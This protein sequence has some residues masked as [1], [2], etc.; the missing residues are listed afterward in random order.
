MFLLS[1]NI[2]NNEDRA[3]NSNSTKNSITNTL[4]N[5]NISIIDN[6]LLTNVKSNAIFLLRFLLRDKHKSIR[7]HT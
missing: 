3:Y 4:I 5:K 6:I 2:V 1:N 7:N